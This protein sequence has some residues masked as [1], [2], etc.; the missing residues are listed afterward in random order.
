[1]KLET[2]LTHRDGGDSVA[3]P[4]YQTTTFR[5]DSPED[6]AE[7]AQRPRHSRFYTRYGNPTTREAEVLLAQLEG[8]EEALITASGM[9]AITPAV[10][11][12]V[13]AGDHVVAQRS[14]YSGTLSLL[15][16]LLPRFNVDVTF[17]EQTDTEAFAQA[18]TAKTVLFVLETPSNPLLKLTDLRA[19]TEVARSRNITTIADNTF[20]TPVNQQPLTCGVDIVVHSATK[21]LNG[22]SDVSAG[23]IAGSRERIER[24]WNIALMTGAVLGP[25][26][27]WLL[28][29]G[30]RTLALRVE[31]QNANA[32]CLARSLETHPRVTA[33][34]YPGLGTHPQHALA[35]SQMFGFGGVLSFEFEGD[36]TQTE[37]MISALR[38]P[39]RAAS[40]GGIETLI[41][42][43]AA[44]WSGAMSETELERIGVSPSLVRL[45]VGIENVSDLQ[46]DLDRALW[47]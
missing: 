12:C 36:G 6:F 13:Q 39:A 5:G 38:I 24:C 17:V 33:V 20:A 26:D 30:M 3:A 28:L 29:R 47:V 31:R 25:L 10:L 21:F 16:E 4:I 46:E 15:S 8:A 35:C 18:C 43:P 9:G 32:L 27:A 1:M 45:S 7:R 19:V 37:R 42:R 23:A 22:H 11:S 2:L 40:L 34:H 44:M 14:L 41:T